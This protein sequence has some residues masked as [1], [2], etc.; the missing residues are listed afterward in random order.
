MALL[1]RLTDAFR[2]LG[3]VEKIFLLALLA[4][5]AAEFLLSGNPI[6]PLLRL[7]AYVFGAWA[8]LRLARRLIRKAIWRLRNRLMVAYAFIAV[9]PVA[10]ILVLAG[11]GI[12]MATTQVAVYLVTSELDQR[13]A[14]LKASAQWIANMP[15]ASRDA[16]IRQIR[17]DHVRRFPGLEIVVPADGKSRGEAGGA[18]VKA[19]RLYAWA[20]V[21][22]DRVEVTLMAPLTVDVLSEMVPNLGEVNYRDL[23][24]TAPGERKSA[25][26]PRLVVGK[27]EWRPPSP[28]G[29]RA[30]IT[31]PRR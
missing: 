7:A 16:S 20:R 11:L 29:S 1:A 19:G 14:S 21:V 17:A 4:D 6:L 15:A 26:V 18:V 12:W 5:L 22:R 24:E 28:A 30:R 31:C 8:A 25:T 3:G 23:I 13:T 10:L 27:K 9:V 2:R